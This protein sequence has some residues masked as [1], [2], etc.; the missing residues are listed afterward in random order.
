MI[1]FDETKAK[2]FYDTFRDLTHTRSALKWW[3]SHGRGGGRGTKIDI[4]FIG[5][6]GKFRL[7]DT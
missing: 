2:G 6:R 3:L 1:K 7:P 5:F 4:R